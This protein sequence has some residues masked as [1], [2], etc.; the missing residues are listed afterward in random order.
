MQA[1]KS[2]LQERNAPI[3]INFKN[4]KIVTEAQTFHIK[5]FML[6]DCRNRRNF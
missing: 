3:A 2:G 6:P 4:E 1:L 5:Y